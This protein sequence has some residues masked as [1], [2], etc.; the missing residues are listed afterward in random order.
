MLHLNLR[1]G[2]FLALMLCVFVF[3]NA[4]AG[5]LSFT[6]TANSVTFKLDKGLMKINICRA[7]IVE[8]KF[9]ILNSFN[10]KESLVVNN[11]WA[12]P[13]AFQVKDGKTDVLITTA[14]LKI[15][16]NKA[17]NAITYMD[18]AGKVI[19]AED[20]SNKSMQAATI[21]GIETYNCTTSFKSPA[22]EALFGMG[23]HPLDSLSINYK[24][25]NQDMAIKYLTGAI[26]VMLSTKGYGLMWDNYSASNF[27][28][29]EAG[30]TQFK[31]VS[32]SGKQ[33]DYYFFYGPD[34]DHIIDSYRISTGKA[35]MF[36]KWAYGLF[37]SQDRY[38]SEAEILTVKDNYRNNHIPVDVLVQDWYYWDPLPIGSHIMKPE[39]YPHPKQLVDALHKANLH[40][41]ISIWPVFGKGTPNYDALEKMGGLTSITWDNVVTHTFDTYYDA[42]NPKARELYWQQARDSLVK[43]YGWDAWWID[44]C[45]PDNGA[46]LDERRKA[47]FSIGKGIDYFN[48][49]SLQHT[50]GVYEGWRRDIPNKRAFFLVRQSFAG[51]QRNAATLWSSDIECTFANFKNQVP[52]GINACVSGI[53]YWTSD[54]GG[55]HY[56]WS[57]PDWSKPEFR[58]LFT[59]WFQ[60]GA[61]SPIFRIHGK[62]ERAI[63]SKNWDEDT[64]KTLL[65]FDNLRYRLLPYIYSLAGRVN[66]DNY[67]MMR[68]L[69]FD[70]K[71]DAKVYG[72]PDQYMFGPAFLVNP[73]TAQLYTGKDA[74]SK[75]KTRNVYLPK[76][77]KWYNFWTGEISNGGQTLNV[78]VPM[79]MMP[80][81]VKAGSII[82]MGPV[83]EYATEKPADKIELRIYP[84]ANG[85]F[86]FYEDENDNYNYEKG[87]KA[88]FEFNY[89][90]KLRQ[91]TIS[92][93]KGSFAGMLKQRVFDIVMVNG[94][95]GSNTSASA[96]IDK[97]VTYT[98]KQM[99]VNL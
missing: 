4:N 14:K 23:C 46:L 88:T 54:I 31:Y 27:Y 37:Q 95:H 25:R 53:P 85:E 13:T 12:Q 63:F 15:S 16:I 74:G 84:G 61:F 79:D 55:Y 45:E 78:N 33:V 58:E 82:P 70:F 86:K 75:A 57:A 17:T 99:V 97:S 28:G 83:M 60:F 30:N 9:T 66:T 21:A 51:E 36:G 90:D 6:K 93:T 32:E 71:D 76:A 94:A 87:A 91:L 49:Y 19:T 42:H 38:L 48:T 8:I 67:T 92:A 11:K 41:M 80:L 52:Q 1:A 10:E 98:G 29:A 68:S 81:Y 50:K 69:A 47:D 7:D 62:G 65:N 43:R 39:R 5:V 89:N 18:L 3:S 20:S 77:T 64:R 22:D 96:T 24:G 73:V 34:F 56:K 26:P 72:I 59:R 44:Q 40:A 35:P 2:K